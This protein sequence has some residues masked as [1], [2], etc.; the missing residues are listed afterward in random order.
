MSVAKMGFLVD[1]LNRDC[2]PLQFLRELTK[3][4]IEGIERLGDQGGELRWDVDWNRVDLLGQDSAQ[5]LCIVD[6][7]LGMSGPEMVEYINKLSSSIHEQSDTGN[8][9]VGAKISAAPLNPEGLVYLSW[10]AGVGSMIHLYKD[11]NSGEYG[12]RRFD[13]GE[14]WQ[15]IQDDL[16]PEPIED[17]GTMVV[18]LGSTPEEATI[19]AP[20]GT[21]MARKWILRYLNSRFF[22]FPP[23]VTVKVREGWDLPRND[24]HNFL[25]TATG[26]EQF[27]TQSS[28]ARGCVDLPE[29]NAR[30]HWWILRDDVDLNSGHYTPGGH[31]AALYQNELYELV[32]GPAGYARLQSFGVVFGAER[33]VLYLEPT[34][35]SMHLLS[36]NTARTQLLLSNEQLEWSQYA[37]EFRDVMPQE[38]RDYQDSIGVS[39]NSDHQKAIRDRLKTIS[40]LFRFGRYR[41]KPGGIH[42]AVSSENTG[43]TDSD[44]EERARKEASKSSDKRSQRRGDIYALFTDE[45]GV[46]A[47]FINAPSSPD[48]V[49]VSVEDGTRSSTDGLDDRAARFLPDQN[50]LLINAD[51][52]AFTDM[53]DRWENRYSDVPGAHAT[54]QDVV[55]EWFEQQLIET[56]MSALALKTGGKWSMQ[57]LGELWNETA[58]TA[59]VL[60][61]Y[62]IDLSIKRVLGQRLGK[63]K[64]AA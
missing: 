31:V 8:F 52:R 51:F 25:R 12:L 57:E 37:A 11:E 56:V 26:Q 38:L 32:Y 39:S 7:G 9:G 45:Q 42:R 3:N 28:Q 20:T 23:K 46:E 48:A 22:S 44:V 55:R 24:S 13:N 61:R 34:G 18:L 60:P 27:L 47:D 63:M 30:V 2:A 36:A 17:H 64:Q 53:T 1:R 59:A 41:P 6:T 40:D 33:V 19:N 54:V 21:K 15:K 35:S 58:L 5:K 14:F 29:S 4:A 43:G 50:K 10:K 16:R 49:W 62:H